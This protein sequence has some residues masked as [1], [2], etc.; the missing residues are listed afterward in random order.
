MT[1]EATLLR[2]ASTNQGTPGTL[3][4]GAQ[5]LRTLE[6]PWKNNAKKISSIPPGTY[7][8]FWLRSPRFGLVYHVNEVANRSS[9]LIHSANFAGDAAAGFETQLQGCIALATRIG[10]MRN[11]FNV[12]QL[13][14]LV[15][16]PALVAFHAWGNAQPITL[17]I[18]ESA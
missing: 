6:L 17:T 4:F 5:T 1:Q 10:I 13:A 12:M 8:L 2:K 18:K 15:S 16:R 11:C 3:F 7:L 14:G 9:V